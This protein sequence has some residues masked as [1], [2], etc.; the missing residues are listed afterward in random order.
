MKTRDIKTVTVL[1]RHYV[2][3]MGN[4]YFTSKIII[5]NDIEIITNISYGY[6]NH[7]EY[8]AIKT[9]FQNGIISR[10]LF[11]KWN[12]GAPSIF[13]RDHGIKY[14]YDDVQTLKRELF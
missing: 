3:N 4:T 10:Q 6:G 1:N 7:F 12:N 9:L 5:N 2:D 11:S 14:M 13:W 8:M